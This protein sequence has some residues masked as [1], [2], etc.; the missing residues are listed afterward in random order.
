MAA[1]PDAGTRAELRVLLDANDEAALR[2]RFA[3]RVPFGT[4]GLRAPLGAGPSRMNVAVVRAASAGV[5]QWLHDERLAARGVVVGYDH[6]HLSDRFARETAGVLAA[7]DIRVWLA[8]RPWPT[9]VTAYAVRHCEAAGGVMVT[10]SHNPAPDNGYKV[11]DDTGAQIV[12]PIDTHISAAIERTRPASEIATDVDSHLIELL[13]EDAI[14][15][16]LD[17]A[18]AVVPAGPRELRVVYTPIHGVGLDI[19]RSLWERVGFTAPDVVEQQ[20]KPDP[21]FPTAPFPNPEEPGVLDLALARARQVGAD[22]VLANDPDADRLAV[23]IPQDGDW[24]VLSG[25]EVGAVLGAHLLATT[26]GDDRVVARSIVSSRLLDRIAA[27]EGVPAR[28]TLTGFKWVSRAGDTDG[29]RLVFGYEEALGYAVT[30]RVRDKDGLTAAVA[31]ADLAARGS[32]DDELRRLADTYGLY[33]TSQWSMRFA[34]AAGAAAFTAHLRASPIAELA[35]VRVTRAV[36][37]VDGA[38]GLPPADLL[39]FDLADG[40]RALVRP[41]GTEPKVKCYFEVIEA[42]GDRGRADER[43]AA[44]RTAFERVADTMPG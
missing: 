30:P 7:R 33:A 15:A 22:L 9:P 19:F 29:R 42:G 2:A 4:A 28:A 14:A 3:G 41:S 21:D 25:D 35:G 8:D 37:Y 40:S 27:A 11:Y 6:R 24:R 36:D 23:A 13:G 20:A 39:G 10:A 18:A 38:D 17:M 1:D 31:I 43:I 34:D 5:A 44:F 32:L 16:Y 12:P 26:A